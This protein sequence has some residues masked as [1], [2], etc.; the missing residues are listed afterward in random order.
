[1]VQRNSPETGLQS[2]YHAHP[3]SRGFMSNH[4]PQANL[5]SLEW[6]KEIQLNQRRLWIKSRLMGA[7][8]NKTTTTSQCEEHWRPNKC[9]KKSS[10]QMFPTP[11]QIFL[12]KLFVQLFQNLAKCV[13]Q[14]NWVYPNNTFQVIYWS[15]NIHTLTSSHKLWVETE[16]V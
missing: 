8:N 7:V 6:Q 12:S 13:I 11:F 15:A 10:K 5:V 2:K 16:R 4:S 9:K 14:D 3:G 1:M